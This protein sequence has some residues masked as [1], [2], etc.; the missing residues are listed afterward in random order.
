LLGG[1]AQLFIILSLDNRRMDDFTLIYSIIVMEI[2]DNMMK[3][4]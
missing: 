2:S 4:E 3:V 1:I